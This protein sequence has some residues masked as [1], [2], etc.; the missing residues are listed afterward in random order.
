MTWIMTQTWNELLF[1]HWPVDT[2]NLKPF[3]PKQL[4]LDLYDGMA[5]IGVVPF[6][7]SHI[8]MRGIPPIPYTT[9]FPELNVRTYVRY[10]DKQGVYFFS[11]DADH[12]PAVWGAR[13]FFHL[14]Y[15]KASIEVS[16][17]QESTILYKSVREDSRGEEAAFQAEYRPIS[18]I[19]YS[20]E[21]TLEHWLTE[22][23][24]L[25]TTDKT[26][27]LLRGDIKHERW[28][29]QHAFA[30]I[31]INTMAESSGFQLIG[32]HPLLHY[33]HRLKVY[34]GALKKVEDHL[35]DYN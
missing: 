1:A 16:H 14:P 25:Y 34:L 15:F 18:P 10:G 12:A 7:M 24:C 33:A 27:Q 32:E 28:P 9:E 22:R 3:I 5:F 6:H 2:A 26:G 31:T 23:Y 21:H 30:N 4:E 11:L 35:S 17:A 13:T 29:L 8:R 19:Y 20:E